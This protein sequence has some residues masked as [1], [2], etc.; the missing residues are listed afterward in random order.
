MGQTDCLEW[1]KTEYKINA[2]KW[3][4]VKD[5]QKGL[6]EKGLTNGSIVK[7][8]KDMVNLWRWGFVE[9]ISASI[10][11]QHKKFRYKKLLRIK[12]QKE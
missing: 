11:D 2:D 6:K 4:S 7:V 12:T 5:V 10:Y 3:F 1:L 8:H 9:M